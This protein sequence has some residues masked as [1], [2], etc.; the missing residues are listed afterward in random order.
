MTLR[1]QEHGVD[2]ELYAFNA[3]VAATLPLASPATPATR[4]ARL[5]EIA[6]R[7]AGPSDT[8]V[9]TD[10]WIALPGRELSVRL[11]RPK[12]GPLPGL[13]YLHGGGWIAGSIATHDGTCAA[14][15]R[16][17]GVVVASLQYRRPPENPWPAPNDDAFEGIRWL[18]AHAGRL[19]VDEGRLAIGGDSAGGHLAIGAALQARDAGGPSLALQLLIYPVIEPVFDTDSYRTLGNTGP[20]MRQDMIE[21]WRHYLSGDLAR[22]DERGNPG[23]AKTLVGL[24]PTQIIIAGMDPLRDE[25]QAFATRLRAAR[26]QTEAV[27]EP[28]LTHGFLRAA[29]FVPVAREAQRAI[30]GG[31]ELAL[32]GRTAAGRQRTIA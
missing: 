5:E 30:S 2:P 9:R 11:Y 13:L 28:S 18:A 3:R 27:E 29:P 15:A 26:V 12:P 17:A 20:L 16:D 8:I 32:H 1:D 25:A 21:Y 7:F 24:P 10:E 31:V 19:G 14:L 6:R 4:R 22:C 23:K